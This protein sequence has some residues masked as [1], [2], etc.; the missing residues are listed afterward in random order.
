MDLNASQTA[1]TSGASAAPLTGHSSV[2]IPEASVEVMFRRALDE[3]VLWR[4]K[5]EPFRHAAAAFHT[6]SVAIYFVILSAFSFATNGWASALTLVVMGFMAYAILLAVGVYSARHSVY[7]LTNHRLMILAGL[8]V[9]KRVSI[10]LK[11]IANAKL[12]TRSNGHGDIL[13][14]LNGEH[15]LSYLLLWPHVRSLRVWKPQPLLRAV[16]DAA[17]IAEK[18]ASACGEYAPIE[19]SLIDIKDTDAPSGNQGLGGVAA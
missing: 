12:R 3:E 8:A 6:N 4:G 5:P 13:L 14:E 11:R 17:I 16:P 1:N 19:R 15:Q 18:L 7:I 10:P 2:E 9:E